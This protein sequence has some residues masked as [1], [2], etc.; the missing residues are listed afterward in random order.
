MQ[1]P[2]VSSCAGESSEFGSFEMHGGLVG[3]WF[4]DSFTSGKS[5][6]SGQAVYRG[7]EHFTGCLD[8]GDGVCNGDPWGTFHT[9]FTFTARFDLATGAEIRGRCHHP[10]VSGSGDF[11]HISGVIQFHDI[12]TPTEVSARYW[13]P[14]RL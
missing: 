10:I 11:A 1:S 13:G 3:C 6:P 5:T 12:V 4:I 8:N 7:T 9:T 14:V 2:P